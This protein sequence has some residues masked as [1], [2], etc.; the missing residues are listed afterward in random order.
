MSRILF[1]I[2]NITLTKSEVSGRNLTVKSELFFR[3]T[4]LMI[5]DLSSL[6]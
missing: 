2:V 6:L 5:P 4:L 3:K 1:K